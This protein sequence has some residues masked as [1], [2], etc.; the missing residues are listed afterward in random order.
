[1]GFHLTS[2]HEL[3]NKNGAWFCSEGSGPHYP[4]M[5]SKAGNGALYPTEDGGFRLIYT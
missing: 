1:M 5:G 4:G 3:A 2:E